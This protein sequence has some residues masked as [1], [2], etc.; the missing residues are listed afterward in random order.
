MNRLDM[1]RLPVYEFKNPD[2]AQF[3]EQ[4]LDYTRDNWFDTARGMHFTN[5]NLHKMD[6]FNPLVD[7]MGC[8]MAEVLT[9]LDMIMDFGF[10]GVW[11]TFQK[12]NGV[13]HPHTHGNSM[14]AAVYYLHSDHE[15][16]GG[17]VF[18]NVI[19][20]FNPF[21]MQ[22]LGDA[23]FERTDGT[24]KQ[25]SSFHHRHQTKWEEG[26][27][28]IFPASIRHYTNPFKGTERAII[29]FNMMPIGISRS[30][31]FSRY[32]YQ[33]FMDQ[34]MQGDGVDKWVKGQQ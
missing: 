11:G 7:F 13:H 17:T 31:P 8:S 20:D 1:F 28:V 15:E 21:R 23:S 32:V 22:K 18:E 34:Q 12:N 9:D 10:T 3:K 29:G 16:G 2:H 14:F 27:L 6:L 30:D 24:L 5:P 26:K 25:T 4:W 33:P 19:A